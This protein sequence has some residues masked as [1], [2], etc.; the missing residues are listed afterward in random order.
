MSSTA[1]SIEIRHAGTTAVIAPNRGAIVTSWRS[2]GRELLYMDAATLNDPSKNVRGGVPVLFPTPGKLADDRWHCM[3]RSGELKQH[4]FARTVAW[5]AADRADDRVTL[6]LSASAATLSAYPWQFDASITYSVQHP[7]LRIDFTVTNR[8][9]TALPF[10]LGF[11]PYFNVDDK[12]SASVASPARR[13]YDN[14]A[15]AVVPFSGFDFTQGEVDLHLL[16]HDSSRA[17]LTL[18]AGRAIELSCS[19]QFRRWVVWSL[20]GKPFV[21]LEPWTAPGNALNSGEDLLLL[22]PGQSQQLFVTMTAHD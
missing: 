2:V 5:Q 12:A 16:D 3:G 11:H 15:K 22:D 1:D 10:A 9:A 13:A 4:G 6:T 14:V 19:P 17:A 7:T 20:P 8:A 21:C 18:G